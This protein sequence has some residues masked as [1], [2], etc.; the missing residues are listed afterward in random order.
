MY[1]LQLL[2]TAAPGPFSIEAM[3]FRIDSGSRITA[4]TY[5]RLPHFGQRKTSISYT[6]AHAL[7]RDR[8]V[9]V[10][11]SPTLPSAANVPVSRPYQPSAARSESAGRRFHVPRALEEYTPW[12]RDRD[13]GWNYRHII[14]TPKITPLLVLF[15]KLFPAVVKP[16]PYSRMFC[17]S[18]NFCRVKI[19][20]NKTL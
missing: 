15:G 12:L 14:L 7:R 3:I 17:F 10:S 16:V 1:F 2:L 13:R 6:L 4:T 19:I 9:T 20:R 18:E 11:S 5:M 8:S